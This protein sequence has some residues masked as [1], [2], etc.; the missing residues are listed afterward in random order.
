MR[1]IKF[2]KNQQM[3]FSFCDVIFLYSDHQHV[4]GTRVAIIR[5]V[6]AII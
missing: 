2:I 5:V 4:S 6:S 3:K 1:Y